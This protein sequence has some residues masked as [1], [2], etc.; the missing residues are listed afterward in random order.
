MFEIEMQQ[1]DA[2]SATNHRIKNK[3]NL[4]KEQVF[5]ND[6]RELQAFPIKEFIMYASM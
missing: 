1:L 4:K 5:D 3:V 6:T 2:V